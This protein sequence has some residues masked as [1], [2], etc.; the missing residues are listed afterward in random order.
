[1]PR[2]LAFTPIELQKCQP[3]PDFNKP[4]PPPPPSIPPESNK[5]P[6]ISL[7]QKHLKFQNL[8]EQF[9]S[10]CLNEFRPLV[11]K[12]YPEISDHDKKILNCMLTKR[13]DDTI[14]MEHA[15]LA[16][17]CWEREREQRDALVKQQNLEFAETIKDKHEMDKSMRQS[18]LNALAQQQQCCSTMLKH[19]LSAKRCRSKH[20][21]DKV[22]YERQVMHTQRQQDRERKQEMNA[23]SL[24]R[25]RLNE[26]IRNGECSA[27]LE[28][29]ITRAT[30]ARN[31]FLNAYRRRLID[32]NTKQQW[33]HATNFDEIKQMEKCK[34]EM[35]QQRLSDRQ[36]KIDRFES[37]K[38]QWTEGQINRARIT[39]TLRDIVR[40]SATPDNMSYRN[41][42]H[43]LLN[44]N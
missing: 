26:Q 16:R 22:M 34:M 20:R 42:M 2:P 43:N 17:K 6:T 35:L 24:E 29:R 39:A 37:N 44:E 40:K 21:L 14:R 1:M 31:H 15:L 23:M 27:M 8:C 3:K 38:M 5:R 32:E 10:T 28:K 30:L 12:L 11:T 7:A 33:I 9:D 36:H 18:R 25:Q 13:M 19:E 41:H 4:S